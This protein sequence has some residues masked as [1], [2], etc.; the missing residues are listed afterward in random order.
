MEKLGI[1][2]RNECGKSGGKWHS[3]QSNETGKRKKA[4]VGDI[5]LGWDAGT[6]Q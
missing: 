2:R 5:W 1:K 6:K 4:L 3:G